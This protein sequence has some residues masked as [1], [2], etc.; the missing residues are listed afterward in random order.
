MNNR[1]MT[2]GLVRA[3]ISGALLFAG[4]SALA[5]E[6]AASATLPAAATP[7]LI[8]QGQGLFFGTTRFSAGGPSCN[9]CHNLVHDAGYGGGTLAMDLTESFG[10]LGADGITDTLPRKGA[11]SPFTVMQAAFQGRDISAGEVTALTAFMQDAHAK[12]A[13]QRPNDIG[14]K[15]L[16]IGIVGVVLL[17]L[18]CAQFG[19][20]RKRRS[21]NQEIFDRQII[22]E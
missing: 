17:L 4:H 19:R 2:H 8:S 16:P 12:R 13:V 3:L 22:S 1:S 7:A 20:G 15:M 14:A 11:P 6:A 18:L 10:R 5:Q 9:A 21:V